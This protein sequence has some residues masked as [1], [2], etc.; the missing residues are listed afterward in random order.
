MTTLTLPNGFVLKEGDK[1][2]NTSNKA[3]GCIQ[4]YVKF[5]IEIDDKKI[6]AKE[7]HDYTYGWC[8]CFCISSE[9]PSFCQFIK[10]NG[11]FI[12]S[13]S[14]IS[15]MQKLTTMLKRFLDKEAQI[16]YKAGFLDGDLKLTTE[17]REALEAILLIATRAELVKAAQEVIDEEEKK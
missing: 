11:R 16:L 17:G 8:A 1:L 10:V 15:R 12:T 5:T 3:I 2:E 13:K 9:F 4:P 14:S 6:R 7:N